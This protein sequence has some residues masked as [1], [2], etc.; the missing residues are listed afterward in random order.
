MEAHCFFFPE[1]WPHVSCFQ[2]V[3]C[4]SKR[5]GTVKK[6]SR[7]TL[8]RSGRFRFGVRSIFRPLIRDINCIKIPA[9]TLWFYGYNF[10]LSWSSTCF[11]H[12]FCRLKGGENKNTNV[13]KKQRDFFKTMDSF[14]YILI[15]FVFL[16]SP[17]WRWPHEWHETYCWPLCNKITSM[18]A[19]AFV[20]L[21]R[22]VMD[23][24]F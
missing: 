8:L 7:G 10:I 4:F 18:R 14:R 22:Y 13:I 16:S 20:V 11:G 6:L 15:I 5:V 3:I 21:W 2:K 23:L 17:H 9:D 12:S 24:G 19:S 1:E